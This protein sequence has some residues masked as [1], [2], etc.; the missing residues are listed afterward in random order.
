ML[1][2]GLPFDDFPGAFSED[3]AARTGIMRASQ[4]RA[5]RHHHLEQF[6]RWI[7]FGD[8]IWDARAC[9]EL[10]IPLIGIATGQRAEQLRQAGAQEVFGDYADHDAIVAAIK[11]VRI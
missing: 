9:T 2:A 11:R 5:A 10:G 7:Y 6:S 3:A 1:S 4:Q 8:A